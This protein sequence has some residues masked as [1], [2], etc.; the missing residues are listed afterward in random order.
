MNS[1]GI[2]A[3][4]LQKR[5]ARKEPP[6]GRGGVHLRAG[7]GVAASPTD[8]TRSATK[9]IVFLDLN[10]SWP[11]GPVLCCPAPIKCPVAWPVAAVAADFGA[12]K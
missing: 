3:R 12:L 5:I 2:S 7:E 11:S 10:A 9:K 4:F 1:A 6:C 8:T